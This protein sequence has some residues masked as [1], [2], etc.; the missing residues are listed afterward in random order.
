MNDR[1]KEEGSDNMV[2]D[3][4]SP[5]GRSDNN[6]GL[7]IV[8]VGNAHI[9]MIY[10]WRLNETLGRVVPDT[11]RGVLD[12]M[13]RHT[14]F[15]YAQSQFALYEAVKERY[16]DLWSRIL[17]RI[18]DGRWVVVGG[19]WVECDSMLPGGESLIRQFLVGNEFAS[20]EMAL[21]TVDIAW[22]PDCF[23]GHCHTTPQIYAGCGIKY[24]VFN[25]G[26]PEDL[27]CFHWDSPDGSRLFAYK[28]PKHYNLTIDE[29]LESVV[30]DWS[31]ISGIA[32]AM[33]L[34]G[35]GDHGGG[36]RD[37]DMAS[38][39]KTSAS[40]TFT[41]S[42]EHGRPKEVLER[43]RIARSDWPVYRGDIGVDAQTGNHRGAHVSQARI[44]RTNRILEHEIL[45]AERVATLGSLCQRKFFFPR[46]DM[47]E[48]WKRYLLH[49]FHDT[50][51]GT[52]VADAADDVMADYAEMFAEAERL[53]RF[54][55]EAI[56]ARVNTRGDGVPVLVFNAS[57]WKRGGVVSVSV[58][59]P[60]PESII[61]VLDEQGH[62]I[63]FVV[64]SRRCDDSQSLLRQQHLLRLRAEDVPSLGFRLYRVLTEEPNGS[65]Q[66]S[67]RHEHVPQD[68]RGVRVYADEH[69][70]ENERLVVEWNDIGVTRI[71]DK[72]LNAELLSQTA[73]TLTLS[74]EN[75]SSSWHVRR[76]DERVRP[77]PVRGP[78]TVREDELEL[79][80]RWSEYFGDSRFDRDMILSAGSDRVDF[81]L[82]VEWHESDYLLSVHIPTAVTNARAVFD[83]PYGAA[84]RIADGTLWPTQKWTTRENDTLGVA[85]L[86]RGVYSVGGVG[87]A[88]ELAVLRGARDMDPR[89][90]EG[91]HDI[92]YAISAFDPSGG[93]LRVVQQSMELAESLTAVQERRH[94]GTLPN[95]GS[96][97]NDF[98][99]NGSHS[100]LSL[101]A[102]HSQ[103]TVVKVIEGDWNPAALIVR[104]YEVD[105]QEEE[106]TIHLP[107]SI[108]SVAEVNHIEQ[109]CD[110]ADE[111]MIVGHQDLTFT[112]GAHQI[113]SFRVDLAGGEH[114]G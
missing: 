13:D 41:P 99:F 91:Q 66:A 8:L 71:F 78:Y 110:V 108:G 15:V 84:T 32:E 55:L 37:G 44:K 7:R 47:R 106:V 34:Y 59:R 2:T 10:R 4:E 85:V 38:L 83:A 82:S 29:E 48:L 40:A 75:E 23:G 31:E 87:E 28:I 45:V 52:L 50:L 77:T 36:P 81:C 22:I 1:T 11:F 27:R 46:F 89:M 20:E 18:Q 68:R 30:T 65:R 114:G 57:T 94:V 76:T 43:A 24:Y 111:S 64:D 49:Q 93:H 33:V 107:V 51:P 73:N 67:D 69:R 70:A 104:L 19:K 39:E 90:D 56:G 21:S 98:E 105:G 109:P 113:R 97:R 58:A 14:G 16:P 5:A 100:F 61:A 102:D 35:E 62:E 60:L 25:R 80:L 53:K 92:Y 88:V 42:L 112:I 101:K 12:V 74:P 86:N 6:A 54:G 72:A 17:K 95:W 79:R 103:L 9:D 3:G 63:P 96:F 26:C